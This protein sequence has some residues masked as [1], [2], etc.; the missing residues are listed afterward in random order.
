MSAPE[1]TAIAS[2]TTRDLGG[3]APVP[4]SAPGSAL[5]VQGYY[6]GRLERDLYWVTHGTLPVG[7][8]QQVRRRSDGGRVRLGPHLP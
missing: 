3:H 4:Q 2:V 5:I 1:A 6:V 8:L 7:V